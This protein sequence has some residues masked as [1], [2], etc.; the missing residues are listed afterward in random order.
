MQKKDSLKRIALKTELMPIRSST[1]SLVTKNILNEAP[2]EEVVFDG[3]LKLT[4]NPEK[5]KEHLS[6]GDAIV[7]E[8]GKRRKNRMFLPPLVKNQEAGNREEIK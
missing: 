4:L 8:P 3:G 7:Y 5:S 1:K 6:S 2:Q